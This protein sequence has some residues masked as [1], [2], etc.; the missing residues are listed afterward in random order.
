MNDDVKN[1]FEE[2]SKSEQE[3]VTPVEPHIELAKSSTA[4]AI[5]KM[6][7]KDHED[8]VSELLEEG[9]GQLTIDVYQ[10][11]SEIVVESTIAG[12]NPEN[13]D[14]DIT[15]ESV[16]IRGKRSKEQKIADEDYFYQECYW[17]KFSRSIILPQEI[18]A[19]KAVATIKNGVLTIRL[20]KINR[21]KSKKVHVKFE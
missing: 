19:E 20:P 9:E 10:T 4:P 18:D 11:S 5:K 16:T 8:M 3:K 6:T 1:F 14:I 15:S 17:G 2:L 7:K 13:L 21:Q 12:V